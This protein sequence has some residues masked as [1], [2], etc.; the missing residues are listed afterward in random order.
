LKARKQKQKGIMKFKEP[1]LNF[2]VADDYTNIINWQ[3]RN[4]TEPPKFTSEITDEL[5]SS[6]IVCDEMLTELK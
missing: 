1:V 4:V 5:I 3:D 2:E 6:M